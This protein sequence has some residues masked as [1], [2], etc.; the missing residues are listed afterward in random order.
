MI[1][2][3][4]CEQQQQP[5]KKRRENVSVIANLLLISIPFTQ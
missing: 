4:K 2:G 1:R 3:L 5:E